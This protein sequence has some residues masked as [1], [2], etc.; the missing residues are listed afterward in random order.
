MN[1]RR[2]TTMLYL[3]G[4]SAVI[5]IVLYGLSDAS[6]KSFVR[7]HREKDRVQ[8][9][10]IADAGITFGTRNLEQLKVAPAGKLEQRCGAGSFVCR[11]EQDAGGGQW[12]V[13]S[14]NVPAERPRSTISRRVKLPQ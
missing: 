11:L 1:R 8:A 7:V 13:A 3:T 9:E 12:L 4:M 10:W 6:I 5:F 14:A 2:G